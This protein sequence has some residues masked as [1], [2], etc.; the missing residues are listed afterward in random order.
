MAAAFAKQLSKGR[1]AVLSG[2]SQPAAAL[3]PLVVNAMLEVGIDLAA[4]RPKAFVD[5]DLR[6]ADVIVTMGCGEAC[7][8]VPGK[9]LEDWQVADP[10]DQSIERVRAVRDAIRDKVADLLAS[11]GYDHG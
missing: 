1:V 8:A 10:K 5:A 4:E 9:R 2:G 3:H 6:R 7:P 11:L